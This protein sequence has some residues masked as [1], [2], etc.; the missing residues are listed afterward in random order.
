MLES[1]WK[2]N[3]HCDGVSPTLLFFPMLL[4]GRGAVWL[5]GTQVW[6]DLAISILQLVG[7]PVKSL[8]Q[9]I[10]TGGTRRLDVPVAVSQRMQ[11]QLVCYFCS[12]HCIWQILATHN[13]II[14]YRISLLKSGI[15]YMLFLSGNA[16]SVPSWNKFTITVK[17]WEQ[18][19]HHEQLFHFVSTNASLALLCNSISEKL[20]SSDQGWYILFRV[21]KN[22][23]LSRFG[24][25]QIMDQQQSMDST[26]TIQR[27]QQNI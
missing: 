2:Y 9:A 19:Y 17:I 13:I 3:F 15:I 5:L 26:W 6:R 4:Q 21:M 27:D 20:L 8:I 16:V 11:A 23:N 24:K 1:P 10:T 25:N 18:G 12:I 22:S 14:P 7:Q